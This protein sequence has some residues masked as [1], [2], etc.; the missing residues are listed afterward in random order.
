MGQFPERVDGNSLHRHFAIRKGCSDETRA[1]ISTW[2]PREAHGALSGREVATGP[3]DVVEHVG[4]GGTAIAK[5]FGKAFDR[6]H[7]RIAIRS[8]V[9]LGLPAN[10]ARLLGAIWLGQLRSVELAGRAQ[11]QW[12]AVD[13]SLPQGATDVKHT[14]ERSR[15]IFA[16]ECLAGGRAHERE[17]IAVLPRCSTCSTFAL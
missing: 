9:H 15:N 2:A 4:N 6:T 14:E 5:D 13:T 12:Q 11:G 16:D 10:W 1:W 7:P 8:M 3:W 17:G